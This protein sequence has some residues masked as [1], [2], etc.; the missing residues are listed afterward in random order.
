MH[1]SDQN[2]SMTDY[3]KGDRGKNSVSDEYEAQANTEDGAEEVVEN[4]AL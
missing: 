2:I 3:N 1:N 4:P